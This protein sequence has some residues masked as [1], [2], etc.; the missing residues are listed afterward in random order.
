[1]KVEVSPV[2]SK[3]IEMKTLK[4]LSQAMQDRCHTKTGI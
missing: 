1:M 3:M 4:S 2:R